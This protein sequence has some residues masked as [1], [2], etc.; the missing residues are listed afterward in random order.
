MKDLTPDV[1]SFSAGYLTD[2]RFEPV[3]ESDVLRK[4]CLVYFEVTYGFH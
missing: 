1:L 3:S 2:D 4:I